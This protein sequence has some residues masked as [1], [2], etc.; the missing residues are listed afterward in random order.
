MRQ[1]DLKFKIDQME[2]KIKIGEIKQT[3]IE[4]ASIKQ[5]QAFDE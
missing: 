3:K 5:Q 4:D 1:T 2:H